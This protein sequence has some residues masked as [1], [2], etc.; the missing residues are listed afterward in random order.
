MR[1]YIGFSDHSIKPTDA[2]HYHLY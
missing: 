1:N 2:G